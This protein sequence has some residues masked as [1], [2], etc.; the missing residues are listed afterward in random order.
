M[1]NPNLINI[2]KADKSFLKKIVSF[3]AFTGGLCCFTP[4]VLVLIGAST[5]SAAASL[6]DTLYY[7]YA[8][9]FRGIS[10]LLLLAGL[11]YYFYV[12]EEVC[13]FD[14][15]KRKR[16]KIIN[17]TLIAIIAAVLSYVIW[18]YVIVEIF[19]VILGIWEWY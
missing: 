13:S 2:N 14:E 5:V 7:G 16:N 10:F 15:L 12:K 4:V 6:S 17:V 3:T 19:G 9:V 8:W 18:L 11:F 1:D